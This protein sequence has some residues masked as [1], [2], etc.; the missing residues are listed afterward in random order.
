[1]DLPEV[2]TIFRDNG[3]EQDVMAEL[4]FELFSLKRW[5]YILCV[6]RRLKKYLVTIRSVHDTDWV[7]TNEH[8]SS[9]YW[10]DHI[11]QSFLQSCLA[12]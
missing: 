7:N 5:E 4:N 11:L 10:V 9:Y 8:I 6:G 12:L 2:C 1:M 3:L